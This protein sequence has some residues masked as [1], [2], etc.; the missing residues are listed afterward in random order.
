M[1]TTSRIFFRRA[2]LQ[3]EGR[4]LIER[5]THAAMHYMHTHHAGDRTTEQCEPCRADGATGRSSK[6]LTYARETPR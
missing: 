6:T 4:A 3:L 2:D 1:Q 5:L